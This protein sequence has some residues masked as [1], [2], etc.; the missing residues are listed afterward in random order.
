MKRMQKWEDAVCRVR[1][2]VMSKEMKWV[3]TSPR[4]CRGTSPRV[5]QI[6]AEERNIALQQAARY[7]AV[8]AA[9]RIT[10]RRVINHFSSSG[11]STK[12]K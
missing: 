10:P 7:T 6:T 5:E 11:R 4:P 3:S 2:D 12:R 1:V 8:D 9:G